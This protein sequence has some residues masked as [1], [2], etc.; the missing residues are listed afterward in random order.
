MPLSEHVYCVAIAF[1]MTSK[2]SATNLLEISHQPWTFLCGNYSVGSEGCCYGQLEIGG[3]ITRCPHMHHVLGRVFF[4][5]HKVTQVTQPSYSP[6]L[7]PCDFWFFPKLKSPLK[8]KRFQITDK[9]QE[10]TTNRAADGNWENCVRSQGA[11]FEG[12]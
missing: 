11:S 5:K 2:Y 4:V 12:A 1:K 7:V 6:D 8:G 10:N 9:I 3:F